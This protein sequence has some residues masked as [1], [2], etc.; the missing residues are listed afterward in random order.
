M[1]IYY[2]GLKRVTASVSTICELAWPL[3]AV[4][5]DYFLNGN[6]LNNIQLVAATAMLVC[7]YGVVRSG[8][9]KEFDF[10]GKV[11]EGKGRG[12]ELGFPTANLDA[13]GIQLGHGVYLVEVEVLGKKYQSLLFFGPKKTFAEPASLEIFI[14]GLANN[15][16]GETIAVRIIKKIRDVQKFDNQQDLRKQIERDARENLS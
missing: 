2:F 15:I 13:E 14:K 8:S 10:R 5:F 7:F 16:Y 9:I 6:T 4:A 3:S 12:R 1:F 11:I